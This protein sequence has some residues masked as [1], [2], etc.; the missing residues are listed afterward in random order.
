MRTQKGHIVETSLSTKGLVL[1]DGRFV[2]YFHN[3]VALTAA[4]FVLLLG[5]SD[6]W[7]LPSENATEGASCKVLAD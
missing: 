4:Y 1:I 5:V 7:A 3:A 2:T 6:S